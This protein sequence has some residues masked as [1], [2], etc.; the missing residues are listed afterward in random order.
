MAA[1]PSMTLATATVTAS[2][3][4]RAMTPALRRAAKFAVSLLRRRSRLAISRPIQVTGWP[5][6]RNSTAG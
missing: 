1:A 3:M 2:R 4:I 6:R 5:M